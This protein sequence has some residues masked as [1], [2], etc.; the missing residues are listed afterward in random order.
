MKKILL[1]MIAL[2]CL[3]VVYASPRSEEQAREAAAK[4]FKTHSRMLRMPALSG[5]TLSLN[6]T[7]MQADS[8]PAF[9]VFN[10]GEDDGFVIISADD[11]TPTV[12][13]YADEGSMDVEQL[14]ANIRAWLDGYARA[15]S[16]V[17]SMPVQPKRHGI[18]ARNAN[19]TS[20]TAISP[21]CT[22]KWNQDAP[23]NLL[24][25]TYGNTK[26]PTGC[27]ATAAAQVMKVHNHPTKGTGSHSYQW[28]GSD[29][30]IQTL[31]ANFGNT[32]YNWSSMKNDYSVGSSTNAQKNAVATLMS[33][34]GISCEMNYGPNESGASG[35]EMMTALVT[36]F[37][38]DPSI[39][40]M[41][42]DYMSNAEYMDAVVSDLQVGRPVFFCGY[43]PSGGGHAFVC[44]G[45]DS[46]G[47]LHINWGWGG[48][49]DGYFLL[50]VLNPDDQGIGGSANNDSYTENVQAY[51]QI[52]P[53][54]NGAPVYTITA[55]HLSIGT[56]R[57]ARN[58]MPFFY[59]DTLANNSIATWSGTEAL[60]VYD[61]N[62]NLVYV[63][64]GYDNYALGAGYYYTSQTAIYASLQSV[65][66]GNYVL[67]PGFTV[68]DQPGVYVPLYTKNLGI[69]RCPMT[70]TND[71]II[72]SLPNSVP[73]PGN[74][75]QISFNPTEYSYTKLGGYLYPSKYSDSYYWGMQLATESFYDDNASNQMCI[76]FGV[77]G[78]SLESFLG[79][80][81]ASA[82]TY[83][84]NFV[85][86]AVGNIS[87]YQ[88]LDADEGDVTI[89]YNSASNTYTVHYS[90]LIEGTRYIGEVTLPSSEVY[91]MY[92]EAYQSYSRWD[93]VQLDNSIYTGLTTS[94]ALSMIRVH[95]VG[96]TSDI[97]MVVEGEISQ[98]VN[99]PAQIAQY[100]N[101]RL[102]ITDGT[103]ELYCFNTKWLNNTDFVTGQEIALGGH[104]VIVGPLK[105]YTST[106]LEVE[107]GYFCAYAEPKATPLQY[108]ADTDFVENFSSYEIDTTYLF[109]DGFAFVNATNE[110]NAY[111][112]LIFLVGQGEHEIPAFSYPI[113]TAIVAGKI[114]AGQGVTAEGNIRGS[115]ADYLNA[116]GG[117][118]APLWFL[119]SGTVTLYEE[120]VIIV[121]AVNSCGKSIICTL[122]N[123]ELINDAVQDVR[124]AGAEGVR[125]LIRDGVVY[126]NRDGQTYTLQGEK[127]RSE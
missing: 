14:P 83:K 30:T 10:R 42:K 88:S 53:N 47:L 67:V 72:I 73:D 118:T 101:C 62:D 74:T 121:L 26:C 56:L 33:H 119:V 50:S 111:I 48:V 38:Y 102:Y 32:T 100:K 78:S 113:D 99:T 13:G 116:Q 115:F 39:R 70:I 81:P 18:R 60:L 57:L 4:Y 66:A 34:V 86:L 92:G 31:S 82:Q 36:Y 40:H 7:A 23:Y 43:T 9:Y 21:I 79:S 96:W 55:E 107:R 20:Y 29:A 45:I 19:Q 89:L 37:K 112:N 127:V 114:Y 84:C 68:S 1:S 103:Q 25:P 95:Q 126:I 120:G 58:E 52:R 91:A 97:P 76:L 122:G 109:N 54:E 110:N 16:H 5:P 123:G 98:L 46:D 6:W 63:G 17:A 93:D 35:L 12:L 85:T 105:Y 65:P 61:S 69:C 87:S 11:C 124:S 106:T 8:T 94:Q 27:V 59:V 22:T 108:D 125:K 71:S 51:T 41:L 15:I 77:G 44:D 24:C 2:C 28:R 75:P 104:A 3:S 49:C 64:T 90:I 117:F 80:Y